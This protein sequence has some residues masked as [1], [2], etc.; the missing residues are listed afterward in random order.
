[1]AMASILHNELPKSMLSTQCTDTV[2]RTRHGVNHA[3]LY[4]TLLAYIAT[5]AKVSIV[6][7]IG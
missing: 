4:A 2:S 6:N 7:M 5:G 3:I 1:M